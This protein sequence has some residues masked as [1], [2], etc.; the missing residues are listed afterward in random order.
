MTYKY[1]NVYVKN[2]ATIVG[3]YEAKGPL[4]Q[5]FDKKYDSDLY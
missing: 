2:T 5:Y 3:P 1:S 4:G